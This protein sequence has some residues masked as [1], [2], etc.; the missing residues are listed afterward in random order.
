MKPVAYFFTAM[1]LFLNLQPILVNC[2]EL[3]KP[4]GNLSSAPVKSTC[5][6]TK[7]TCP[8]AQKKSCP[9]SKSTKTENKDCDRTASC[10]PF[11]SCSQCHY[12]ATNKSLYFNSVAI[13]AKVRLFTPNEDIQSGFLADCWHPPKLTFS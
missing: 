2:Q 7:S 12:L 5:Q 8:M 6:K 4:T 10:N 13:L 3:V 1:L 11:A 9:K